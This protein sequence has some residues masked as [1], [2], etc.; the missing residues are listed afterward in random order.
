[1]N[2]GSRARV[3]T[4][5]PGRY[6]KQLMSHFSRKI[7]TEW[8]DES[9]RGG[10][11]F[12]TAVAQLYSDGQALCFDVRAESPEDLERCERVIA[13]HLVKF[14]HRDGLR[15]DFERADGSAGFSFG[16]EDLPA[17]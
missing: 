12:G 10:C 4:D 2:L 3:A 7:E 5:R 13:R 14:G 17:Q 1:M 8:D 15:M 16:P 11:T 9:Q 6:G